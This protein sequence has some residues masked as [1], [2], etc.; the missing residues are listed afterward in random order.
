M[1]LEV[2]P[3]GPLD[4]ASSSD[5]RPKLPVPNIITQSYQESYVSARYP[6]GASLR[7]QSKGLDN[8][9]GSLIPSTESI[10][11]L[12]TPGEVRGPTPGAAVDRSFSFS[13]P[14]ANQYPNDTA[15]PAS[16]NEVYPAHCVSP[17]HSVN[18]QRQGSP[19]IRGEQVVCLADDDLGLRASGSKAHAHDIGIHRHT[20]SLTAGAIATP[21]LPTETYA[22]L[23]TENRAEASILAPQTFPPA[24]QLETKN[25]SPQLMKAAPTGPSNPATGISSSFSDY[26]ISSRSSPQNLP[27]KYIPRPS[28]GVKN[29]FT[30]EDRSG[31]GAGYNTTGHPML[32]L[33]EESLVPLRVPHNRPSG[34]IYENF[35]KYLIPVGLEKIAGKGH[36]ASPGQLTRD[37]AQILEHSGT[38]VQSSVANPAPAALPQGDSISNQPVSSQPNSNPHTSNESKEQVAKSFFS[39]SSH[40]KLARGLKKRLSNFRTK[41]RPSPRVGQGSNEVYHGVPQPADE[42]FFEKQLREL[43][44]RAS[45]WLTKARFRSRQPN[46]G[47]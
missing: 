39:E 23:H 45:A 43:R 17:R 38:N 18:T 11:R 37:P 25:G 40:G 7:D 20:R 16:V 29:Y 31:H 10:P 19:N 42:S 8:L 9:A 14:I 30:V 1:T 47:Q 34:G 15:E 12:E 22:S 4:N 32:T 5:P 46:L 27:P 2:K 33:Q 35:D 36:D 44:P 6:R 13:C 28:P 24:S 41:L 21:Q 3:D 26:A